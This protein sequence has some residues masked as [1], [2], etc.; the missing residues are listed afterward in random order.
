MYPGEKN[1]IQRMLR[2]ICKNFDKDAKDVAK[3]IIEAEEAE[4]ELQRQQNIKGQ[5]NLMNTYK[6]DDIVNAITKQYKKT[7]KQIQ[8]NTSKQTH[9][10]TPT[11]L[12]QNIIQDRVH[13]SRQNKRQDFLNKLKQK[14]AFLLKKNV[15]DA[16]KVWSQLVEYRDIEIQEYASVEMTVVIRGINRADKSLLY[17]TIVK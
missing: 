2:N 13:Q 15:S 8:D 5:I 10:P 9:Q 6:L 12:K 11:G 14:N 17:F 4:Y 16:G 7:N 3:E 1:D